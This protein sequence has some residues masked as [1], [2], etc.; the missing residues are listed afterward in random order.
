MI[1]L[2]LGVLGLV[3]GSFTNAL[4][5]RVHKRMQL[6]ETAT[7]KPKKLSVADKKRVQQLSVVSGRSRCMSCG[8][9]LA[10]KDLIPV[11]SWF[12]LRGKCRYCRKPI[13]DTPV[14]ELLVPTLFIVSYLWWPYEL[15]SMASWLVFVV[16]LACLV[17]FAALALYDLRWYLLPDRIVFPLIGIAVLFR[18]GLALQTPE[19]AQALLLSGL[20]GAGLLFGFFYALFAV[21]DG[22]WIGGGDVKLAVALGLLSGGPL[23]VLFL[24]FTAS[25]A[26]TLGAVPAMLASKSVRNIKV[27]FG[28]FL[29][30][31]TLLTVLFGQA[32]IDWYTSYFSLVAS[33]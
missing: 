22:K 8:H 12:W 15:Q 3:F 30:L 7:G 11:I 20:W 27:P 26:G 9:E 10:A 32:V 23:A 28:P 25:V 16:W 5:W 19:N 33:L 2:M 13:P 1:V 31:A 17:C 18:L 14:A 29:L 4:I 21:S 24:L 6:T